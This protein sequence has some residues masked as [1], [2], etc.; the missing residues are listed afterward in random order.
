MSTA[1]KTFLES[2]DKSHNKRK[3]YKNKS[4]TKL[5]RNKKNIEKMKE[6]CVKTKRDLDDQKCYGDET[7]TSIDGDMIS[8]CKCLGF[9]GKKNHKT[10]KSKEFIWH[11]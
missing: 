6:E 7:K 3:I 1:M 2:Q 9:P 8:S 4:P 10:A 11:Q 5:K